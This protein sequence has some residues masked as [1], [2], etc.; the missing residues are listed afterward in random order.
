MWALTGSYG[1]QTK[2]N[3]AL[4][5]SFKV[6]Q[7]NLAPFGAGSEESDG[8]ST[9]FAFDIGLLKKWIRN[10]ETVDSGFGD[11]EVAS[12]GTNFFTSFHTGLSISNIGPK[13][14]FKDQAQADPLPTNMK[15][16]VFSNL[17]SNGNNEVNF[18]FDMNKLLVTR[19]QPMDWDE[20]GR[21]GGYD[22]DGIISS[23]G[24]YNVEG[25]NESS[26]DDPWYQAIVTSWFDDWALGG[27]IDYDLDTYI[28]NYTYDDID[29]NG[30]FTN[31]LEECVQTSDFNFGESGYGV[32]DSTCENIEVGS[33]DDRT[34]R[35]EF[36]EMIYNFGLEYWYAKS[37]VI[38][39][40]YIYDQ[41][42]KITNP[43]FGAGI[44]LSNYGFDF[45]YTAGDQGHPRANT[46]FFS[47][48]LD[49]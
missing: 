27:D 49:I 12:E 33:D 45:G 32:F 21:I 35:K 7:Q 43:T 46:M 41:D 3:T 37:F 11:Y 44:R 13:I 48:N 30:E 28:G 6:L 8:I 15:L 29:A 18:L 10:A 23:N 25:Q 31:G 19:Y 26:H 20:D 47:I 34:I 1:T 2:R 9:N 5:V 39:L 36:K 16:G 42:G 14:W 17:F 40:G 24:S 22:E 4:G 38:R